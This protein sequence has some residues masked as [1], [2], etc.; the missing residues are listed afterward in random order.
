M[1]VQGHIVRQLVGL[2]QSFFL[3]GVVQNLQNIPFSLPGVALFL[4]LNIAQCP[5]E[6]NMSTSF[7]D[8]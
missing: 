1:D 4:C 7:C 3:D 5:L 8:M 6:N 2:D